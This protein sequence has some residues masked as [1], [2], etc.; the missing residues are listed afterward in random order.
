M[1]VEVH[2]TAGP[3]KGKSFLFENPGRLLFGRADDA[4]IS[5][6]DDRYVSRRHFE[7]DIHPPTCILRDLN[8]T[9]GVFVNGVHYGGRI[10]LQ[11]SIEQI[12][13]DIKEIPLHDGD[14]IAVRE[15]RIK[16]SIR[17]VSKEYPP[18][19][20]FMHPKTTEAANKEVALFVLNIPQPTQDI[21]G[22]E[23]QLSPLVGSIL[24]KIKQHPSSASLLFLKYMNDGFLMAFPAVSEALSLAVML[25]ELSKQLDIHIH[26][27]VHWGI[28]KI[29]PDGDI[30]GRE[31]HRVYRIEGVQM[32]NQIQPAPS[33]ETLPVDNRILITE[34]GLDQ[35]SVSEREQFRLVGTF[36]LRGFEES[37]QLW[38]LSAG[39]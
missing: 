3:A 2:V 7:L 6:P 38:V 29:R 1:Y 16:V 22:G 39:K 10:P 27:A 35:I 30:F 14:E 24:T 12:P 13:R 9:N 21:L 8:S 34:E 11:T 15:T 25:L 5:V 18:T 17:S 20:I 28:V 26:M 23:T 36:Q 19:E 32:S 31:V 33:G 4:H 37:C